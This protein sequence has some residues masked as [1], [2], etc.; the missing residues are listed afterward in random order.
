MNNRLL[1][2]LRRLLPLAPA[3]FLSGCTL[4]LLDPRGPV[5]IQNRT[6]ILIELGVML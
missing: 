5:G 4:D 2:K 3:F 6:V 1:P